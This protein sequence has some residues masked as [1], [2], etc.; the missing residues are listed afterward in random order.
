MAAQLQMMR[1]E[2]VEHVCPLPHTPGAVP[3]VRRRIRSVLAQWDLAPHIA[4]DALLV[5]SELVTNA[6]VHAAP[7]AVL[8]LS[9]VRLHGKRALR[10]AVTD[11]GPVVPVAQRAGRCADHAAENGRGILIVTALADRCGLRVH[12]GGITRWA[13]LVAE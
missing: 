4:E 2:A 3:A 10:I 11:G 7:L 12:A 6:V 13:D 5:V 1:R 9:W 8:R